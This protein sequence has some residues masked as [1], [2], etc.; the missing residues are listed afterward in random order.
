MVELKLQFP[1]IKLHFIGHLQ[2]KKV[3]KALELFDVIE[4]L[5][6][7]KLAMI[8]HKNLSLLDNKNIDFYAQVN[9]GEETQKHGINP[10]ETKEFIAYCNNDL[11]LGI[12]GLMCIP[13][14]DENPSLYF[15]Y[16]KKIAN[17]CNINYLSQGMSNDFE[18]AIKIS[19]NEI[20]IGNA[21]F[22]EKNNKQ[23]SSL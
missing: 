20:R 3:K 17:E 8:I 7:E 12:K 14:K 22:S 6:S 5:D 15:A 21:L 1:D 18:E 11:K 16:L 4:T 23:P 10:R 2:S 13:P 9:I 19:S